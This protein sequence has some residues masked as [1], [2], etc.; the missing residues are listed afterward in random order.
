MSPILCKPGRGGG[1]EYA[2]HITASARNWDVWDVLQ[3]LW[4]SSVDVGGSA[5]SYSLVCICISFILPAPQ[6]KAS[7]K[8]DAN[9]TLIIETHKR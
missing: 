3:F 9:C 4:G 6:R 2:P 5:P 1:A 7:Q 8:T